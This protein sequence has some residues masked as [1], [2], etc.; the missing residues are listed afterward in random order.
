MVFQDTASVGY[1]RCPALG[2]HISLR[3]LASTLNALGSR[4]YHMG[5]RTNV[6][7]ST[8]SYANANRPWQIYQDLAMVLIAHGQKLYGKDEFSESIKA[9]DSS[10]I[11]LCLSLF[12]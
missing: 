2:Y 1:F 6:P 8:L 12:P 10:T 5:I 3:D 4:R 11:D 7:L 9:L